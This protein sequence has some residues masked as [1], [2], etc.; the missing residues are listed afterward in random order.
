MLYIKNQWQ[1]L[2]KISS[3]LIEHIDEISFKNEVAKNEYLAELLIPCAQAEASYGNFSEALRLYN[4]CL[5]Y[6]TKSDL[7]SQIATMCG[8][9]SAYRN[10]GNYG[11]ARNILHDI[12][13]KAD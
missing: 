5:L 3:A 4:K 2:K 11:A 9:Y 10:L 8:V 6:Q 7:S 1:L 12:Q 13:K